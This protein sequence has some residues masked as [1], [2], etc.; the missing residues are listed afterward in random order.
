[1]GVTAGMISSI[2][3]LFPTGDGQGKNVATH[4]PIK[5]AAMEGLFET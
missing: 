3:M 2:M 4:Q 1:M 5:L